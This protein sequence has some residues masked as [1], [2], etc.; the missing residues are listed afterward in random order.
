MGVQ[1]SAERFEVKEP[2]EPRYVGQLAYYIDAFRD[3]G[4]DVVPAT[5]A[6]EAMSLVE[7][8]DFCLAVLDV[9]LPYET[10][11]D[12]FSED[13]TISGMR[14]GF[15]LAE[16]IHQL[17]A[18]LPIWLL[19]QIVPDGDSI[20]NASTIEDLIARKVIR[21]AQLKI[22]CTD[23]AEFAVKLWELFGAS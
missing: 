10:N 1:E 5:R 18:D 21:G 3:A 15:V 9:M 6:S 8:E 22:A 11:D 20:V 16:E 2:P 19:S 14:T 17:K 4:F 13:R 23:P 7:Q 12:R